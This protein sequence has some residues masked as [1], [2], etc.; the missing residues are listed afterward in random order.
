MAHARGLETLGTRLLGKLVRSPT[1]RAR[2]FDLAAGAMTLDTDFGRRAARALA[3]QVATF[4]S[5]SL[6]PLVHVTSGSP[7]RITESIHLRFACGDEDRNIYLLGGQVTLIFK[8]GKM[9]SKRGRDIAIARSPAPAVAWL[10]DAAVAAVFPLLSTVLRLAGL[11][12]LAGRFARGY[13]YPTGDGSPLEARAAL[14]AVASALGAVDLPLN[15]SG[16]RQLAAI[17]I[18]PLDA[19]LARQV[20]GGGEGEDDDD[21]D[22]GSGLEAME[23]GAR[24]SNGDRVTTM[25]E[26][27]AGHAG[28]TVDVSYGVAATSHATF[29]PER[30]LAFQRTSRAVSAAIFPSLAVENVRRAR[31]HHPPA[32]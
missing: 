12:D 22:G 18:R 27:Q 10:V 4:A 29:S 24:S 32:I 19:D 2:F 20:L 21:D 6:L 8:Y 11:P 1:A 23:R 9:S 14:R 31:R 25:G 7:A 3:R 5:H 17:R 26:V 16:F 28:R 15:V 13:L 30:V